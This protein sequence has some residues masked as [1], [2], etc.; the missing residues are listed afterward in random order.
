[1]TYDLAYEDSVKEYFADKAEEYDL[2]DQQEYW[3]LSDRLLWSVFSRTLDELPEDFRFLD[4]GGGTGRWSSKILEAYP[5]ARGVLFDLSVEMS[6]KARE[7]AERNGWSDRF[8]VVNGR[9]EEIDC[10]PVTGPF[11]IVFN[12]HNVLGFVQDVEDVLRR[13]STLVAPGGYLLSFV[14]NR[15]HVM[16]F[17]IMTRQ[18]DEA[19]H[20]TVSRRGRFTTTMPHMHV[21]TPAQLEN[22]YR[23]LDLEPVLTTGFPNLIYPGYQETQLR[24]QTET[25]ASILGDADSF[26]RIYR[27]ERAVL[28]E[29]GIAPR[30]NNLYVLGRKLAR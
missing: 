26:E 18:L 28:E 6:Q 13:L 9:L 17:N 21:F 24:G 29:P 20:P 25:L 7:K 15:Y 2:V 5:K 23:R 19:E 3:N 22:V 16:F 14:P 8:E 10:S 27:L 4:A 30:S 12:F 11:D 1:M